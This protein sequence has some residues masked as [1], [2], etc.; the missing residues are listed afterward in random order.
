MNA[1][2]PFEH[3]PFSERLTDLLLL[4]DHSTRVVLLATVLLGMSAGMIGVFMVLRRRALIGDVV[5]HSV[6]PGILLAFLILENFSPGSGRSVPSLMFGALLTGLMGAGCVLLIDRFSRIKGDAALAIVLALFYGSGTVLLTI[7]QRLDSGSQAG[8]KNYLYGK[9]ASLVEN[10]VWIAVGVSVVLLTTTLLLFKEWTLICFDEEF[11]RVMGLPVL[12][13]DGL[14]IV[15]VAAVS[16]IGM[17]S[18]GLVLVVA[19]LIIPAAGARFWT[20]DIRTM[21]VISAGFGAFSCLLGVAASHLFDN[22]P[23]GPTIVLAG[24]GLFLISLFG[25]KPRGIFWKSLEQRRMKRN[26]LRQDLM[27][28]C[29][30]IAEQQGIDAAS[31]EE[32]LRIT[33]SSE[34]LTRHRSWPVPVLARMIRSALRSGSLVCIAPDQYRLTK[35]GAEEAARVTRNYRLWEQYLIHYAEIAPSQVQRDAHAIEHVLDDE[36]ISRLEQLLADKKS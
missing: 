19:L 33:F 16:V 2:A 29:Y 28:T 15:L 30:E 27:R 24:T 22:V 11:A 6:L 26:I 4:Q 34:Q 36:M 21:A 20:D 10:D 32:L 18:V 14:L 7:A 3:Q 31:V 13:L 5:G 8:L 25:S 17:N 9:T 35:S 12:W 1:M 23:A